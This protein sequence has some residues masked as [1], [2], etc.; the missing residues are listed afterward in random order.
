MLTESWSDPGLCSGG[1]GG[2]RVPPPF[3]A[4]TAY[5]RDKGTVFSLTAAASN[6][7]QLPLLFNCNW[8]R[9]LAIFRKLHYA[10]KRMEKS[11]PKLSESLLQLQLEEMRM[12]GRPAKTVWQPRILGSTMK[13]LHAVEFL[14][15]TSFSFLEFIFL[16]SVNE[17]VSPDI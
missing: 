16:L 7:C 14:L 8:R 10:P 15:Y 6:S 13:F 3:C 2:K 4:A 11:F 9:D 5:L 12:A 1:M 17:L